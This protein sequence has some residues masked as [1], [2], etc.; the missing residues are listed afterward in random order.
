M[1][2]PDK[3]DAEGAGGAERKRVHEL[4]GRRATVAEHAEEESDR[5]AGVREGGRG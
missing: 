2:R 1:D 3:A 5:I 4:V